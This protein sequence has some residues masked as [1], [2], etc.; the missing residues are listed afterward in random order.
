MQEILIKLQ[1]IQT[2]KVHY[3]QIILER[4][5]NKARSIEFDYQFDIAAKKTEEIAA[6]TAK[7][8]SIVQQVLSHL[9]LKNASKS[10]SSASS[11]TNHSDSNNEKNV[12]KR[13]RRT[14]KDTELDRAETPKPAK[15]E[16]ATNVRKY[17]F[18]FQTVFI[19]K[20]SFRLSKKNRLQQQLPQIL[21]MLSTTRK[22]CQIIIA[23]TIKRKS[24]RRRMYQVAAVSSP[25]VPNP[26]TRKLQL[27]MEMMTKRLIVFVVS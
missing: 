6:S 3:S 7:N 13:L 11:S 26:F 5:E 16:S 21:P 19:S 23:T 22:L 25:A 10:R 1:E 24:R 9:P 15:T 20:Y 27:K 8:A 17:S 4:V 2:E 18:D 14:R 12:S